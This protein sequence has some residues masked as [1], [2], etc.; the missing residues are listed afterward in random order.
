MQKWKGK[1]TRI[2]A[3]KLL[4]IATRSALWEDVIEDFYDEETDTFPAIQHMFDAL[5][6]TEEEYKNA[7]G[8]QNIDWPKSK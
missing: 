6:V 8:A 4:E 5:G 1:L 2:D 7:T 3:I